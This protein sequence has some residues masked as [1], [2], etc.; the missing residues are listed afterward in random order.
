MVLG[1]DVRVH[2]EIGSK[3][4][5]DRRLL[6]ERKEGMKLFNVARFVRKQNEDIYL[7][8]LCSARS[9]ERTRLRLDIRI[10]FSFCHFP[11]T[12]S[13]WRR[14]TWRSLFRSFEWTLTPFHLTN[15]GK[16]QVRVYFIALPTGPSS[17]TRGLYIPQTL[18]T[19]SLQTGNCRNGR[20]GCRKWRSYT[21]TRAIVMKPCFTSAEGLFPDL[22]GHSKL[23][24]SNTEGYWDLVTERI[25]FMSSRCSDTQVRGSGFPKGAPEIYSKRTFKLN[26]RYVKKRRGKK[27]NTESILTQTKALKYNQV[28]QLIPNNTQ[29]HSRILWL[30]RMRVWICWRSLL[31]WVFFVVCLFFNSA[32]FRSAAKAHISSLTAQQVL[33]IYNI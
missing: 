8:R 10:E 1:A 24:T 16:Y 23:S 32:L 4:Q 22:L 7:P 2:K 25:R 13:R 12:V 19:D 27:T 29:I 11:S 28:K 26:V 20:N 31:R 3:K 33:Y 5:R 14:H 21:S 30:S 9:L 15:K 6:Y 18:T 17:H